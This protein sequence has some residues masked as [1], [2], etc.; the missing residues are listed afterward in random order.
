MN[1]P[2]LLTL[3]S[4][5]PRKNHIIKTLFLIL[6]ASLAF[7]PDRARATLIVDEGFNYGPS[8]G[9]IG[10]VAATGSGLSGNWTGTAGKATYSPVGLSFGDLKVGGGSL[11]LSVASSGDPWG[12]QVASVTHS[13]AISADGTLWG[14]YLVTTSGA[15]WWHPNPNN[16]TAASV[17]AVS[18]ATQFVSAPRK[19]F[20]AQ[21]NITLS[22]GAAPVSAGAALTDLQT[23]LVIFKID[24]VGAAGGTTQ[25]ATQWI[26]T[27]D[28][29]ANFETNGLTEAGLNSA[30]TGTASNAV[31]QRSSNSTTAPISFNAAGQ[32]QFTANNAFNVGISAFRISNAGGDTGLNEVLPLQQDIDLTGYTLTFSDEFNSVSVST[33]SPKGAATWFYWPPYGAAGGYSSSNWN[34]NA[35]SASGGILTDLC[36]W[37]SASSAWQSGQLSSADPTGA[38]FTQQYGYFEI[39]CKMPDAGTGAWPAFWLLPKY[40][41]PALGQ[42]Q[43]HLEIDIFEWYGSSHDNAPGLVSQASHNW[44]ADDTQSGGLYSPSTPMPDGSKPWQGFHIYGCQ[45]DPVHVTWYIDGVQTNQ[46]ATPAAYVSSPFYLMIDYAIGGASGHPLSGVPFPTHGSSSLQVDWVRVYSLPPSPAQWADND[47]GSPGAAGSASNV[48]G[49]FTVNGSGADIWGTSDSFNYESQPLTGDGTITA[50]VASLV[51]TNA[52]AKAGVMMRNTLDA[53]SPQTFTFVTPNAGT[54][55]QY[56]VTNGGSTS[57]AAGSGAAPYW[58]RLKRAGNVFTSYVSPN[59]TTWTQVGTETITM[60]ST[61]Y[62]GLAVCSHNNPVLTTATF[63]NVTVSSP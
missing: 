27:A 63:D 15:Y 4:V 3:S 2:S 22:G 50:R 44:N 32:F 26:L 51:N 31:L 21:G 49:T 9:N 53:A 6:F 24:N 33:A 10:G 8:G 39:R 46:T 25:T 37:D 13:A 47:I 5:S 52:W 34:A 56:R 43:N 38:G 42:T 7:L 62:V 41:I 20:S 14:S 28:Q 48:G 45:V 58:V 18:G 1:T 54:G 61:I 36:W 16:Y 35:F 30:A 55:N 40:T 29:F 17:T 11:N 12:T 60:N 59:G 23:N 57:Y 19:Y